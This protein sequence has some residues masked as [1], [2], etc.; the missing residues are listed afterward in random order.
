MFELTNNKHFDM[1]VVLRITE[2]LAKKLHTVT[3]SQA[4]QLLERLQNYILATP[5]QSKHQQ[6]I[7]LD[8][9]QEATTLHVLQMLQPR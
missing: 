3:S 4:S 6:A 2:I 1:E 8:D 5:F 9:T 7:L